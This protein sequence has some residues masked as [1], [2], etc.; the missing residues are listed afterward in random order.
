MS[1]S[2]PQPR[3]IS[4]TREIDLRDDVSRPGSVESR[5]APAPRGGEL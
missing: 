4:K 2:E 1:L 3:S 5:S